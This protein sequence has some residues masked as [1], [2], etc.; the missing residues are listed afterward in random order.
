VQVV[1]DGVT[2]NGEPNSKPVVLSG[3]AFYRNEGRYNGAADILLQDASWVRLRNAS[4]S[5]TLSRSAMPRLPF[6]SV[7]LSVSGNN[8]VLLTPFKGFDPE[9]TAFGAGSNAFGYTGL[10]IPATRNVTV[11]AGFTF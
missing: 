1:F 7:R 8:L 4:V 11:T 6:Q 3:D 10:N 9:G 2:S 5:Y